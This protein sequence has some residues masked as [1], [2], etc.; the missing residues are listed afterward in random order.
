MKTMGAVFTPTGLVF[1]SRKGSKHMTRLTEP[2]RD[3]ATPFHPPP[4]DTAGAG[5]PC[6]GRPC[7]RR[8][9][10]RDT[11]AVLVPSIPLSPPLVDCT[12]RSAPD[13]PPHPPPPTTSPMPW[14]S[15]SSTT[16]MTTSSVR[17]SPHRPTLRWQ[18]SRPAPAALPR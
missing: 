1:L 11:R 6:S 9:R 10:I 7:L 4:S 16:T 8:R 5:S 3:P 2:R 14:S 12:G 13:A 18:P 17:R 15:W